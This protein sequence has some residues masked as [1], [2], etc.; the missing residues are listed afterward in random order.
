M[1]EACQVTSKK[2]DAEA[3]GETENDNKGFDK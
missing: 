2:T 3:L 1:R